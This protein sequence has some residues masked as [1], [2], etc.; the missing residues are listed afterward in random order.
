MELIFFSKFYSKLDELIIIIIII[1]TYYSEKLVYI[2][3]IRAKAHY[4]GQRSL[5]ACATLS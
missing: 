5:S 2:Y 4:I 3:T 1:K